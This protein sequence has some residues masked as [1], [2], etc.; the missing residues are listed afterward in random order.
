MPQFTAA[1]ARENAAKGHESRRRNLIAL[2]QAATGNNTF[3]QSG[4]AIAAENAAPGDYTSEQLT[5]VRKQIERLNGLLD[6]ESDPQRLARLAQAIGTMSERERQLAGRP[7]P[8]SLRPT[9]DKR[10]GLFSRTERTR[11]ARED[12]APNSTPFEQE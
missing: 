9:A 5:R 8:G 3:S 7:L 11:P 10:P 4:P 12:Q 2:K 1:N 6:E